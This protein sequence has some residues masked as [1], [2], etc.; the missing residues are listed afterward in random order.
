MKLCTAVPD[1]VDDHLAGWLYTVCR[2]RALDV[3]AKE[4]RMDAAPANYLENL[5][6]NGPPPSATAMRN[7]THAIVLAVVDTMPK[8]HQE[9]FRLKFQD[10]LSY[11]EIGQVLGVS[12]GTVSNLITATLDAVRDRLV[13]ETTL[14]QEV[15]SHGA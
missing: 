3:R 4:T 1:A 9:A 6:E 12:I 5:P 2:N 14:A 13:T 15:Q 7:E 10:G 11:R 8:K